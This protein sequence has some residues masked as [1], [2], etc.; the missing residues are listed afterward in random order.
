[1]DVH[2]I[3]NQEIPSS[4]VEVMDGVSEVAGGITA[5]YGVDEF[6]NG[7]LGNSQPHLSLEVVFERGR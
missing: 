1:M 5:D 2:L 7:Y 6:C 4:L 3:F